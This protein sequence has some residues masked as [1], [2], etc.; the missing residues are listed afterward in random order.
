V[1]KVNFEMAPEFEGEVGAP[2]DHL[3]QEAINATATAYADDA[4]IDVEQLLRAQL[5]SHA[6][7]ARNDQ[8]IAQTG[9]RI[10]SGHHVSIAKPDG[11]VDRRSE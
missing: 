4:G 8:W 1:L 9:H 3:A 10:R 6:I 7:E 2:I 11:P 5:S